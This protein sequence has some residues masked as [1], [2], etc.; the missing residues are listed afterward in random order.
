MRIFL[1]FTKKYF[2]IVINRSFLKSLKIEWWRS[3]QIS[4][5]SYSVVDLHFLNHILLISNILL[6]FSVKLMKVISFFWRSYKD[7]S[8]K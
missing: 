8:Y 4:D 2:R 5:Y 1:L 6:T 3:N 7:K